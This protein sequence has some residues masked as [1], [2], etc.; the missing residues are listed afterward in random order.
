MRGFSILPLLLRARMMVQAYSGSRRNLGHQGRR[1]CANS[2]SIQLLADDPMKGAGRDRS[3]LAKADID[4][5]LLQAR[6]R[7][8]KHL[9][10]Q[11]NSPAAILAPS[12][13]N[14]Q[15]AEAKPM[16]GD[17]R[18]LCTYI[19]AGGAMAAAAIALVAGQCSPPP[20]PALLQ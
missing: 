11:L 10:E 7:L 18:S 19:Y 15:H 9:Q 6:T 14:V 1:V 13:V 2:R 17:R 5:T 16:I 4:E 3:R 8:Q 20:A 12:A